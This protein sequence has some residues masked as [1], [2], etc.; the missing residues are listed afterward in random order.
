[1]ATLEAGLDWTRAVFQD[2][3]E[4]LL[5]RTPTPVRARGVAGNHVDQGTGE[6]YWVSGVK[7][8][9]TDRHGQDRGRWR[10]IPKYW[11]SA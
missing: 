7:K 1:M 2:W 10:S 9:G 11:T 8:D 5:Q 3:P 6:E 4:F